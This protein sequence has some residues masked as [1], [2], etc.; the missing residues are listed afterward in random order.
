MISSHDKYHLINTKNLKMNSKNTKKNIS[1][2]IFRRIEGIKF[3]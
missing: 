2:P 1:E 3:L